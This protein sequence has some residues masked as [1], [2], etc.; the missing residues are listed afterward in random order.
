VSDN[1][2]S[3]LKQALAHRYAIE[4]EIGSGGMATV[5]LANDLKLGRPV[6]IKVAKPEL[7]A[8][9]GAERFVRE[10]RVTARL[11]HPNILPLLDS[12]E[13]AGLPYFVMPY[14][15]GVDVLVGGSLFG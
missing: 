5:Y 9:V 6:A 15:E 12:G 14:V 13:A 2:A 11:K 8:D 3:D 10:I 7:A 1:V 4:R